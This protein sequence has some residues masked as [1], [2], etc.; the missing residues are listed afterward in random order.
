MLNIKNLLVVSSLAILASCGGKKSM[1]KVAHDGAMETAFANAVQDKVFF[2]FDR[3]CLSSEAKATLDKQ[4]EWIKDRA[5]Q[6]DIEVEGHCDIRGSGVY[7][8]A[9]GAKRAESAKEYLVSKGIDAK[10]VS[11]I[12]YG[13]NKPAVLGNDEAAHAANRRAVT[14]VK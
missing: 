8:M 4:A 3:S 1:S 6:Q 12:S 11:I 5:A 13:K 7:N 10:R 14:V 2:A 9:L